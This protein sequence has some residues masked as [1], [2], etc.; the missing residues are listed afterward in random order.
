MSL[1]EKD[2]RVYVSELQFLQREI[3]FL[4]KAAERNNL[5][6]LEKTIDTL[7]NS[8]DK[9]YGALAQHGIT[10]EEV[11]KIIIENSDQALIKEILNLQKN[12]ATIKKRLEDPN[13]SPQKRQS[14]EID[15]AQKSQQY[16]EKWDEVIN[17]PNKNDLMT[18]IEQAQAKSLQKSRT[19][20]KSREAERSR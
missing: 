13:I 15:L 2:R 4:Q 17:S 3:N 14:R 20:D 6:S 11:H 12:K 8:Q 9:L 10:A 18:K 19:R 7:R 5:P 1:D 16:T